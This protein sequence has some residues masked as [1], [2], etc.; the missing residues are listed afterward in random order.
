M[1]L[2]KNKVYSALYLSDI[3]YLID[4]KVKSHNHKELFKLLD[5]FIEKQIRFRKIFLVGDIIE[6]WYFKG[7]KKLKK[8]KGVKRF[9]K[10]FDRIDKISWNNKGKF[11]IIGNHDSTSFTMNL[12]GKIEEYLL[13]RRY[14][15]VERFESKSIIVVHGHQGQYNRFNWVL[16]ILVV[17]LLSQ[18]SRLI[19]GLFKRAE[20]FYNKHLNHEDHRS[21]EYRLKYYQRLSETVDQNNRVL[22]SGHTHQFLCIPELKI[23]N[24]GNWVSDKTF[25]V[26][27]KKNFFGFRMMSKKLFEDVFE[28]VNYH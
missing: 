5:F 23:M 26:Q 20:K 18:L 9:N 13:K 10:F 3:H 16:A 14:K 17:R 7:H 11:Y 8:L 28:M 6:N 22:I 4:K 21:A 19:P 24:T 2:K 12:P 27:Q 25:I 1:K 15:I